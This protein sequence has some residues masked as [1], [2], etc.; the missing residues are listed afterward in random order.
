MKF[1]TAEACRTFQDAE[2]FETASK[3]YRRHVDALSG[4]LKPEALALAH[5]WGIRDGLVVRVVHG[6]RTEVMK[7]VL[8]CGDLHHGYYNLELTYRGA[9]MLPS[10]DAVLAEIARCTKSAKSFRYQVLFQELDSTDSGG[11]EHRLIFQGSDDQDMPW[12]TVTCRE[13]R[14]RRIPRKSRRLPP[15]ADRY[16][17]ARTG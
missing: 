16:P 12:I 5:E 2:A 11:I 15:M 13:L 10:H 7:L 17:E 4:R 9:S 8:R 6:R 1:F 14:W 3:A